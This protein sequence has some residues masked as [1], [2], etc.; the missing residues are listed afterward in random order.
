MKKI[1]LGK[2][3][4]TSIE[5]E[6]EDEDHIHVIP[7]A[8]RGTCKV[9][10]DKRR[11]HLCLLYYIGVKSFYKKFEYNDNNKNE[12]L[13][14]RREF[15]DSLP[16]INKNNQVI[17]I[18]AKDL[19]EKIIKNFRFVQPITEYPEKNV[20]IPP[21]YLGL[22][23]GDGTS[24]SVSITTIDEPVK[25]Y[26]QK[27]CHENNLHFNLGTKQGTDAKT[28]NISGN[29]GVNWLRAEINR[30]NLKNNKHH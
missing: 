3:K 27:M 1:Q 2:Y 8:N 21:Y 9:T 7:L 30:Y 20:K 23:L 28:C 18:K 13:K 4:D 15:I 29:K 26:L 12:M 16:E 25:H 6:L 14:K 11:K 24:S 10:D 22:W 19:D 17:R 5:M